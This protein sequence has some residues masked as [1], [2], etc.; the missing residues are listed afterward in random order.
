MTK[1]L[2]KERMNN[3]YESF[4]NNGGNVVQVDSSVMKIEKHNPLESISNN[5]S[6]PPY[7]VIKRDEVVE[8]TGMSA[9]KIMANVRFGKFPKPIIYTQKKFVNMYW[10]KSEVLNFLE[11]MENVK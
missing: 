2:S 3:L 5:P 11:S 1:R 6:K 9:T 4:L 8:I 10:N 7:E